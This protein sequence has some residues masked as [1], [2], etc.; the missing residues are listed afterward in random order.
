MAQ[1]RLTRSEFLARLA[2]RPSALRL[3]QFE[4]LSGNEAL[5]ALVEQAE[6]DL[7]GLSAE[8]NDEGQ[9]VGGELFELRS[10]LAA[11]YAEARQNVQ[12]DEEVEALATVAAAITR[13]DGEASGRLEAAEQR[14]ARLAELD[15]QVAG[16]GDGEGEGGSGEGSG[17]GAEGGDGGEG[18][19]SGEGS[20]DGGSG[21]EGGSGEGSGEQ[22][23]QQAS[24]APIQPR[25]PNLG[26]LRRTQRQEP[27]APAAGGSEPGDPLAF[28]DGSRVVAAAVLPD[29]GNGQ[30][31]TDAEHLGSAISRLATDLV[32]PDPSDR[33][34]Y[35]GRVH[36]P[37][38]AHAVRQASFR[39]DDR[40]LIDLATERT[41]EAKRARAAEQ[42][43]E[44]RV[45]SGGVCVPAQPDY[46]ITVVGDRGQAWVDTL[47]TVQG[48][49][50][51]SYFPWINLSL[52]DAAGSRVGARPDGGMGTV[53]AA[54]DAAGYGNGAGQHAPKDCVRIDCPAPVTEGPEATFRCTTVGN[55]QAITFPEYVRAF[56]EIVGFYFDAYRDERAI[57]KFVAAAKNLTVGGP[58]FGAAR[59]L[60]DVIR[61]LVAHVRSV[62][63]APNMAFTFA[64]PSFARYMVAQDLADSWAAEAGSTLRITP[65]Q[66]LALLALDEGIFIEEYNVTTGPAVGQTGGVLP[67]LVDGQALPEWPEAIRILAYPEGGVFRHDYGEL[68][69]GLRETGVATNDF[70]GFYEIFE[71]TAFR[72]GDLFTL[73]VPLCVNGAAGASIAKLC[74]DE[75]A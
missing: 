18:S 54:Q 44:R 28:R 38:R 57:A 63:K 16:S 35:L 30:A 55:F 5:V 49:R 48:N 31:F 7:S 58:T 1:H 6:G 75:E 70:S 24:G 62:R 69:F 10:Q 22:G 9:L 42:L 2:A 45:A 20:G 60:L 61:R 29:L 53:T 4:E 36:L 59:D 13:L 11:A 41:I 3:G 52:A 33:K 71:Q 27:E 17:D 12:S 40:S 14:E 56:D 51:L 46:G 74:G 34:F 66:A 39:G 43:D 67:E 26:V 32:V 37:E 15:E 72:T 25:R 64:V 21:G 19:G 50:P 47:P 8:F 23:S 68:S 73:D 65:A